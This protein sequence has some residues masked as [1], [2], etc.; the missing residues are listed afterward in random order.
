MRLEPYNYDDFV[1]KTR[2]VGCMPDKTVITILTE[3]VESNEKC[4]KVVDW[5]NAYAASCS[6]S[7]NT[8]IRKAEIKNVKASTIKGEVFLVRTDK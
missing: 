2:R 1:R 4:A 8:T 7:I 3:F 6:S 5:T